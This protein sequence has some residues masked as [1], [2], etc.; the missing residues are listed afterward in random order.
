MFLDRSAV[1]LCYNLRE[2]CIWIHDVKGDY[3]VRSCSSLIDRVTLGENSPIQSF[4]WKSIAPPKV[5]AYVWLAA[6]GKVQ[7]NDFL[8][9]IRIVGQAASMC[10]FAIPHVK[11]PIFFCSRDVW[12]VWSKVMNWCDYS[13]SIPSTLNGF[14]QLSDLFAHGHVQRKVW[15]LAIY[16]VLWFIWRARNNLVFN[17]ITPIWDNIL[18]LTFHRIAYWVKSIDETFVCTGNDSIKS[19]EVV[20]SYKYM[21]Y[22]DFEKP[23]LGHFQM[24]C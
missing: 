22:N 2:K 14:F 19:S 4:V 24:E 7:T 6:M 12:L 11:Q 9:Q 1:H 17:N 10:P 21:A 20:K 3:T 23:E 15:Y 16:A 5:E 8:Q 13:W 18:C